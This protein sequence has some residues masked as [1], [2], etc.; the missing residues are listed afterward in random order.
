[1]PRDYYKILEISH[2]ADLEEIKQAAQTKSNEIKTTLGFTLLSHEEAQAI[3]DET[4][5]ACETLSKPETRAAYD[6]QWQ[7]VKPPTPVAPSKPNRDDVVI[8]QK[9]VPPPDRDESQV[10]P[11]PSPPVSHHLINGYGM[12]S[13]NT[14]FGTTMVMECGVQNTFWAPACVVPKRVLGL[15][16][17][18]PKTCLG[19]PR[20]LNVVP[21]RVLGLRVF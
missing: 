7:P 9:S 18:C 4:K 21:K 12:R 8:K 11:Y 3:I 16:V 14:R 17:F 6:P 10:S 13:P 15:R 19:T 20:I 2:S 1:M 5:E